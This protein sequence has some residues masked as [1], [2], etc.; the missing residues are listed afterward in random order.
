M[1]RTASIRS[2]SHVLV[3]LAAIAGPA[4]ADSARRSEGKAACT[5]QV[6]CK[7]GYGLVASGHRF[8][9]KKVST[10]LTDQQP[11]VCAKG[12][13][14]SVDGVDYCEFAEVRTPDC[15]KHGGFDDWE[16]RKSKK[17]CR[18]V[19]NDGHEHYES[20]NITCS[21]KL[22]YKAS[23]G[24]CEGVIRDFWAFPEVLAACEKQ[25][26]G[27]V[28]LQDFV[29]DGDRCAKVEGETDFAAPTLQ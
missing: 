2:I 21:P 28:Y 12:T 15:E 29:G 9:C 26:P 19:G 25:L 10:T 20:A 4:A 8:Y 5:K 1:I 18:R 22:M 13:L 6:A 16:W 11:L 7:T 23:T 17:Q 24:K 27:S 3:A 14:M